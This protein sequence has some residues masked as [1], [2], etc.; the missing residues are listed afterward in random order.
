MLG[1]KGLV[2]HETSLISCEKGPML[3]ETGLVLSKKGRPLQ[4]A[5][6]LVNYCG[7]KLLQYQLLDIYLDLIALYCQAVVAGG[8]A[9]EGEFACYGGRGFV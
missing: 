2:L 4:A 6:P 8:D 3:D 9:C 5:G 7:C 1:E